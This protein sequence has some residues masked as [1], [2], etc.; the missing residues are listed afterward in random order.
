[1]VDSYARA[2]RVA[3]DFLVSE[4]QPDGSIGPDISACYKSVW[5]LATVGRFAEGT[6]LLDSLIRSFYLPGE[7]FGMANPAGAYA[8]AQLQWRFL[9]SNAWLTIGSHLLGRFEIS[10]PTVEFI[11]RYQTSAGGFFANRDQI[12]E[13]G[14]QDMLS[15][16]LCG[17]TCL[18]LGELDAAKKAAA[19]V[20]FL[21]ESQPE[22]EKRIYLNGSPRGR[23]L[24]EFPAEKSY[25]Y[26]IDKQQPRQPYFA[27][28]GAAAFL[29]KLY[30]IT[31]DSSYLE[32]AKR[33]YAMALSPQ[34]DMPEGMF[35][36]PTSGKIGWG[37]AMIFQ[38]TGDTKYRQVAERVAGYLLRTQLPNGAWPQFRNNSDTN[39]AAE[40]CI[41]LAEIDK[42]LS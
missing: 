27:P 40:F 42:A 1:M 39:L 35:D 2:A 11:L 20:H 16:A 6:Q 34:Q 29:S 5:P 19:F 18:Y 4:Q 9:Y 30:G 25:D 8:P 21:V 22:P 26:I 41:W 28:G 17:L 38:A 36:Y 3:A 14:P 13:D 24:T 37:T 10:Y 31:K 12:G 7:G 33:V 15:T 32:T 23:L